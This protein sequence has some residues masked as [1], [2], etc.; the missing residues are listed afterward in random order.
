L[1]IESSAAF[2]GGFAGTQG[3]APLGSRK[4]SG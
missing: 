1:R 4:T 3:L 2:T